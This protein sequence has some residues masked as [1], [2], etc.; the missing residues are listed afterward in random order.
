MIKSVSTSAQRTLDG[1]RI[2][3]PF[4]LITA[5]RVLENPDNKDIVVLCRSDTEPNKVNKLLFVQIQDKGF[6][7]K[8]SV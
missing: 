1:L 4:Q 6:D 5:Y 2:A 7:P 8:Y 3:G